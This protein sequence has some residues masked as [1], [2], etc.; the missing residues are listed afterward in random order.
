MAS[1]PSPPKPWER[2]A[3]QSTG[4]YSSATPGTLLAPTASTIPS[5]PPRPSALNSIVDRLANAQTPN[6]ASAQAARLHAARMRAMGPT[7]FRPVGAVGPYSSPYNRMGASMYGS[8][9]YGGMGGYG[10]MY[11]G[12]GAY[13]MGGLQPD[14]NDPNS[15]TNSFSQSTQATFQLIESLVSAFGGFAQMLESTYMTTHSS[16]FA[17]VS[18]A[19]QFANL[20]TTLGSILGI[21][22]I[23]R[24]LK[25][26]FAT[27]T[28]RPPPA[29]P[30]DLTP[31]NFASFSSKNPPA[32]P[33]KKP[34][35]VFLLAAFGLPYLMGKLI[36]TL[37][38]SQDAELARRS[39]AAGAP[40]E[41]DAVLDPAKLEF[42]EALYDFV[43]E[44]GVPNVDVAVKK[45]DLVAVLA[46]TDP[47]G[48]ASE[49]WRCRT[50]DGRVGYLPSTY[51]RVRRGVEVKLLKGAGPGTGQVDGGDISVE[52]FQKSQFYS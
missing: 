24:W 29:S 18:V 21:F 4:P 32:R 7:P 40:A 3:A 49:W 44:P 50:R 8:S 30:A 38:R 26:L 42:C 6:A 16:F 31:S 11:N 14:P 22:T 28:G 1:G 36:T 51:L 2:I 9:L 34:L 33:S 19:E 46:K 27:L 23:L 52:S 45:G 17:M 48:N 5:L 39:A 12:M 47:T 10:G 25:Q 15:L 43:P 13:G 35:L 41:G 37:A 20:R